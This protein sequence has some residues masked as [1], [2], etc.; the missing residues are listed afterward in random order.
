MIAVRAAG[1]ADREVTAAVLARAFIDDPA[2]AHLF[3]DAGDR[4]RRL[5]KFFTLIGKLDP[6]PAHWTL[7]LDCGV[8]VAAAMWRPPGSWATPASAMLRLLPQL[9]GTFGTA[10]PRALAM[11]AVMEAHHPQAP[12]WYLQF[13]GCVPASQGKGFGGAAI[14]DR[15]RRCDVEAL[16]AALET[17]TEAN[18]GLY[19]ALGFEVTDCYRIKDGPMFWTMWRA[20]RSLPD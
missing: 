18:L 4:P 13:A 1:E 15:L 9:L 14:R 20:P 5:G 6:T 12:H 17:A 7:A 2:M 8:P 16:P 19:R 3:R 11:Q 10:L